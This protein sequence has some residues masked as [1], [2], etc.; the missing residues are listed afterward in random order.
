MTMKDRLCNLI[1]IA[2]DTAYESYVDEMGGNGSCMMPLPKVSSS[3][4]LRISKAL[5]GMGV[6]YWLFDDLDPDGVGHPKF[7][8]NK[9]YTLWVECQYDKFRGSHDFYWGISPVIA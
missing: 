1:E 6:S 3:L 7:N 4:L 8:P 5:Y 2:K 9:R